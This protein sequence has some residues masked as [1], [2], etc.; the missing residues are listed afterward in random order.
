MKQSA[1]RLESGQAAKAKLASQVC[2]FF[3]QEAEHVGPF[4]RVSHNRS[5]VFEPLPAIFPGH[6]APVVRQD[7]DGE[8]QIVLMTG[9][10]AGPR[11]TQDEEFETW[12]SG[13]PQKALALAKEFS[14][15][16]MRIVQAGF[17]K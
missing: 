8:R 11:R 4:L 1:G 5:I 2:N 14:P 15:D 7:T 13:E 16:Q 12:L 6:V 10:R 17:T 3:S 9:I